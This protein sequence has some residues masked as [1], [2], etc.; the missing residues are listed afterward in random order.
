MWE[1]PDGWLER[2]QAGDLRTCYAALEGEDHFYAW[3]LRGRIRSLQLRGVQADELFDHASEL[4]AD[5]EP[6]VKDHARMIGHLAFV[7]ENGLLM[8]HTSSLPDPEL[9]REAK[10]AR[11]WIESHLA[12]DAWAHI[13]DGNSWPAI[14]ILQGLLRLAGG[15]E[16]HAQRSFWNLGLGAAMA[17]A[18]EPLDARAAL[19]QAGIYA[20]LVPTKLDAGRVV[21]MLCGVY[22]ELGEADEAASWMAYLARL[23]LPLSTRRLIQ[24][25]SALLS[26]RSSLERHLV[27]V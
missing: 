1:L 27:L 11:E 6:S 18:G 2:Y 16:R 4:A 13:N 8:G 10:G 7:R 12:I 21:G 19:E 3:S 24:R 17:N 14:E 5:T 20:R 25:R 9:M 26:S 23:A 22:R 15:I